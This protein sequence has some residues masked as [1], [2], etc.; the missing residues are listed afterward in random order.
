VGNLILVVEDDPKT[1]ELV[2]LY[3]EH[4]GHRVL[5]AADGRTGLDLALTEAPDLVLLDIM[6][7]ELDGLDVCAELRRRSRVP[8]IFLTAR[9]S[10]EDTLRGLDD[11]ADD[12][13]TKPFSPRELAARVRAV[14]RRS[15][16]PE[17]STV[18]VGALALDLDGRTAT[19]G[20][21]PLALT[22][23]EFRLLSALARSPGRAFSRHEL[24]DRVCG[25]D[26][27]GLDRTLDVHVMNLRKKIEPD[28]ARPTYIQTVYG[29]GYK[30]ALPKVHGLA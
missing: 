3:L 6:L 19:L 11:G 21:A 16:A 26:Y 7:P 20:E 13:I 15:E 24:L 14:L 1:A 9:A 18:R 22:P 8:V 17:E 12:Y 2:Q 23:R 10:E 30:L 29:V 4:D 25:T 28:P 27:D 5:R